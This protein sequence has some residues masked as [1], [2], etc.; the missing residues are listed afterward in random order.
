[1]RGTVLALTVSGVQRNAER[2]NVDTLGVQLSQVEIGLVLSVVI[3]SCADQQAMGRG[4]SDQECRVILT[5][6]GIMALQPADAIADQLIEQ[7]VKFFSG[8]APFPFATQRMCPNG[9]SAGVKDGADRQSGADPVIAALAGIYVGPDRG[10]QIG[11]QTP[12][13]KDLPKVGLSGTFLTAEPLG[14]LPRQRD[15][16]LRSQKADLRYSFS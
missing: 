16:E 6:P 5:V 4:L 3:A 9:N 8:Q 7:R 12:R 14:L 11:G 10:A 1:M 13:H 2:I 15:P